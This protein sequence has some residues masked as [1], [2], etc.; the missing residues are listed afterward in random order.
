MNL[1]RRGGDG[2]AGAAGE[3]EVSEGGGSGCGH[4]EPR[5]G[6][7]SSGSPR[8][9]KMLGDKKKNKNTSAQEENGNKVAINCGVA[10]N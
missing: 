6:Q 4:G 8:G 10:I 2:T 5:E 3:W 9:W 7:D 1:A